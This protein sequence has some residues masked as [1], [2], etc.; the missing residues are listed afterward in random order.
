MLRPARNILHYHHLLRLLP[1]SPPLHLP[2]KSP[3][4]LAPLLSR[5]RIRAA[6]FDSSSLIFG[7]QS[8]SR[9][10]PVNLLASGL[11]EYRGIHITQHFTTAT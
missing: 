10:R 5:S 6:P 1:R 2:S 7:R 4:H 8:R 3:S 9:P 11:L